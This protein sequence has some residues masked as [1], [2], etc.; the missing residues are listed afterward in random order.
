MQFSKINLALLFLFSDGKLHCSNS[1]AS[2]VTGEPSL[3]AAGSHVFPFLSRRALDFREPL[4][5]SRRGDYV[6]ESVEA[7]GSDG[8]MWELSFFDCLSGPQIQ[9]PCGAVT[10]L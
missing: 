5:F 4:L 9:P 3:K 8:S 10:H 6:R 7:L 2:N 1:D